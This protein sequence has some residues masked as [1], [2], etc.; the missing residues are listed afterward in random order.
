M[1]SLFFVMLVFAAWTSAISLI[2]PAVAWF[3]EKFGTSRVVSALVMG[4]LTWV[5]GVGSAL[6]FNIWSD[7]TLFGKT[8]FDLLDFLTAN[9]MLPLGGLLIAVFAAW[10]MRRQISREALEMQEGFGFRAW[11]F[12]VRYV[13]PVAVIMIFLKAV[14]VIG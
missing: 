3:G 1:A 11:Y 10:V 8:F 9:I 2:E 5:I 7:K 12:L 6:S 14:G 4:G 13:T